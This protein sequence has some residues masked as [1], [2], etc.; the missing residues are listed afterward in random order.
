[1]STTLKKSRRIAYQGINHEVTSVIEGICPICGNWKRIFYNAEGNNVYTYGKDGK[2]LFPSPCTCDEQEERQL[3][4][5][6]VLEKLKID[7]AEN[8]MHRSGFG[9][10]EMRLLRQPYIQNE[11]NYAAQDIFAKWIDQYKKRNTESF[12]L[13]GGIGRGKTFLALKSGM[14]L[15]N[16]NVYVYFTKFKD[17]IEALYASNE[18][19]VIKE[20]RQKAL[21]CGVLILDDLGAENTTEFVKSELYSLIDKRSQYKAVIITTN[22]QLTELRQRYGDRVYSRIIESVTKANIIALN[23]P[24][25]SQQKAADKTKS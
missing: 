25:W 7:V 17:Y 23:G 5:N 9:D 16:R 18:D 11:Y 15:I 22:L 21:M 19:N 8:L 6:D 14:A 10:K 24:P 2:K 3:I 13:I 12:L 4:Q 20:T 1:M